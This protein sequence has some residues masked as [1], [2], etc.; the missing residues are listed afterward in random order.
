MITGN[1]SDL[2]QR[3]LT[4]ER[5]LQLLAIARETADPRYAREAAG[6]WIDLRGK[7]SAHTE[8]HSSA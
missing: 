7:P 8:L 1:Q 5:E 3:R 6:F 2:E 4:R